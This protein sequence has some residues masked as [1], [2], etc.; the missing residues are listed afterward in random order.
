[1]LKSTLALT[2]V[3]GKHF[4]CPVIG[5]NP[6]MGL[7]CVTCD[8]SCDFHFGQGPGLNRVM[9]FCHRLSVHNIYF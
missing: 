3:C 5:S 9:L 6:M 2:K 4:A 7:I 1:M 8:L